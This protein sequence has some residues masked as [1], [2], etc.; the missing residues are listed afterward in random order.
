MSHDLFFNLFF[1]IFCLGEMRESIKRD[2]INKMILLT[3]TLKALIKV[4][5]KNKCLLEIK[6]TRTLLQML[7]APLSNDKFLF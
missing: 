1:N 3:S 7:N 6:Q 4:S 2:G 5:S